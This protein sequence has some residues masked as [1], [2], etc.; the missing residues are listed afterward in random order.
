M[1]LPTFITGLVAGFLALSNEPWWTLTSPINSHVLSIQASPFYL[2][3]AATGI[4]TST[5]FAS[6]LG[7][8]TRALLILSS[9][10]L[11]ASSLRPTVWW[12]PLAAWLS[13]ASLTELFFSLFLFVHIGQTALLTA[14]G[15]N[16]PTSGTISYPARIVG[17]DLNTYLNPSIAATFNLDFYLGLLSLTIVGASTLLKML[18]ERGLLAAAAIPGVKEFFLSPPYR[19]VWLSTGDRDLNPLSRDPENTTDD[20]LLDSF[21]KIYRTVQPGGVISIILPQW[22]STISDRFQKLLTWTGFAIEDAGTIYRAPGKPEMQ[23]RF[24]KPLIPVQSRQQEPETTSVLAQAIATESS[25]PDIPPQLTVTSPA[26]WA[27]SKMTKQ[28]RATLRSA[29]SILSKRREPVLYR[30][31][32]NQVYME[33]VERKVEFDSARQIESTLLKHIGRELALTE[34]SDEQGLKAVKKWGL[35]EEDLSPDRDGNSSIFKR[36]SSHR[37]R[38]P[39]V[40]RLLKKW[41]RKPKQR[42]KPRAPREEE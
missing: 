34:E 41:Q 26:D 17:T 37:P 11:L 33:L 32:L 13:L 15:T 5:P 4:P 35:G 42:Y 22:A 9:L 38:V 20:E 10:A 1:D 28:E 19:H 8:L 31:L 3:I 18:Q 40:M 6:I 25:F 16:P 30:E 21:G 27:P 24:R 14:Y 36:L 2:Q 7:A 29:V 12:R 39:P 23:L